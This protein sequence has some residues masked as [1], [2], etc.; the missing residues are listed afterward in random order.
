MIVSLIA[1]MDEGGGIGR[2]GGLP[3]RL[4]ADLRLFKA[5]TMGHHLIM[6]RKTFESIGAPLPG[7]TTI[8]VTRNLDYA[9]E[10]CLIAHSLDKALAL[11]EAGGE[12]EA[13]IV[14]GGEIFEQSMPYAH[15]IYM[16]RVHTL[17]DCDVYFPQLDWGEWQE[18]ERGYHPQ[19]ERNGFPFTFS[20]WE[21]CV[22]IPDFQ[23][24]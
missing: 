5:R 13:F 15:R 18:L 22:E 19:D 24:P 21:K 16:T 10:G 9:A 12:S 3:W 6:G 7:R 2:G 11:A 8:V 4:S 23:S 20:T 1:A 14:G 17:A